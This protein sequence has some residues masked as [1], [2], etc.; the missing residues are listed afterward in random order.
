MDSKLYIMLKHMIGLIK[1]ADGSLL[2]FQDD[3]INQVHV[4]D[5]LLNL[6]DGCLYITSQDF[7]GNEYNFDLKSSDIKHIGFDYMKDCLIINIKSINCNTI[8]LVVF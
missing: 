2:L 5:F 7:N 8:T 3:N 1:E 4:E 6:C